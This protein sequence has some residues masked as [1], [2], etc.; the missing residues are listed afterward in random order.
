MITRSDVTF[1]V[2]ENISSG[3]L[4]TQLGNVVNDS[5]T[6][7]G[8]VYTLLTD[9]DEIITERFAVSPDGTIYTLQSLDREERAQYRLSVLAEDPRVTANHIYQVS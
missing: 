4:V 1:R 2:R 5:E 3:A 6:M 8:R 9:S 7:S